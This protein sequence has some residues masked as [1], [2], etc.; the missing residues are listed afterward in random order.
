VRS[1]LLLAASGVKRAAGWASGGGGPL[2]DLALAYDSSS[3]TTA[4]ARRLVAAAFGRASSSST[5]PLLTIPEPA[6]AAAAARLRGTEGRPLVGVHVSGGRAIKQWDPDRFVDVAARLADARGAT[7]VATGAPADRPLVD[8]LLRS[9]TP[10]PVID[11]S[12]TDD[13]LT[14]AAILSRLDLVVTGDTGPMHLAAAVGTPVVAIFG[15]SD[16]ARYATHGPLDRVVRTDLPCS[17]CNRIRRPPARCTGHTPDC[18]AH[19][20][21][22]DVFAAA[23]AVLDAAE[24]GRPRTGGA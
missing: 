22:D 2:L 4:N 1:N 13:L 3:H 6:A 23:I 7:I 10:R 16:P 5:H 24:A 14:S 20:A 12:E 8:R 19:V 9:L 11:A 21:V 15:P 17:P 18:L